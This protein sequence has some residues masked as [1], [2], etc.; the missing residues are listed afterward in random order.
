MSF[1]TGGQRRALVR[2]V[3]AAWTIAR[4]PLCVKLMMPSPAQTERQ[5]L[6]SKQ[7]V[8][9]GLFTGTIP[10]TAIRQNGPTSSVHLIVGEINTLR[11]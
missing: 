4:T 7:A 2:R 8:A 1:A 9:S 11:E 10:T 5:K 3:V 6:V